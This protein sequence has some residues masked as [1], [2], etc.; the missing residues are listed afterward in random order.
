M[1][2]GILV[3]CLGCVEVRVESTRQEYTTSLWSK[4][5]LEYGLNAPFSVIPVAGKLVFGE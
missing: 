2:W 5:C 1:D 4:S 3:V